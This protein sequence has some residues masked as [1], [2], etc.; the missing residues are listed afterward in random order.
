MQWGELPENV[1]LQGKRLEAP[2]R[3]SG[4]RGRQKDRRMSSFELQPPPTPGSPQELRSPGRSSGR[5]TLDLVAMAPAVPCRPCRQHLHRHGHF[6]GPA[7][8]TGPEGSGSTSMRRSAPNKLH[9]RQPAMDAPQMSTFRTSSK[10]QGSAPCGSRGP[11]GSRFRASG[12]LAE[13]H[14]PPHSGQ[15]LDDF[16]RLLSPEMGGETLPDRHSGTGFEAPGDLV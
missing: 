4:L 2:L 12:A 3:S 9:W 7:G 15:S 6:C 5:P 14:R 8:S 10:I 1:Y 16:F 13:E 11:E